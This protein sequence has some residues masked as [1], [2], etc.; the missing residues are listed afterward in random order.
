V[1][2]GKWGA[3]EKTFKTFGSNIFSFDL[4]HEVSATNM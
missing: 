1:E 4:R 3:V 2:V